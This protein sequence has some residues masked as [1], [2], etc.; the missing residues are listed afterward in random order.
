M[1]RLTR[2]AVSPQFTDSTLDKI[3][4]NQNYMIN[5]V[6]TDQTNLNVND[7]KFTVNQHDCQI[8]GSQP[9]HMSLLYTNLSH[10]RCIKVPYLSVKA[11]YYTTHCLS[12]ISATLIQ[13]NLHALDPGEHTVTRIGVLAVPAPLIHFLPITTF[14]SVVKWF[15][16]VQKL[17][18]LQ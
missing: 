10:W 1:K 15:A 8:W 2:N 17:L 6:F 13:H 12:W 9:P 14:N 3:D 7:H 18:Q 4:V 16:R 5:V 11:L